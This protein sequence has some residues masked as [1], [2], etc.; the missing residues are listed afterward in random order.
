MGSTTKY[1]AAPSRARTMIPAMIM[2]CLDIGFF[3]PVS[4]G[5]S[6]TFSVLADSFTWAGA[7]AVFSSAFT[8][9]VP[10]F[11][12]GRYSFPWFLPVLPPS[13][14]LQRQALLPTGGVSGTPGGT[15]DGATCGTSGIAGSRT[16]RRTAGFTELYP[17]CKRCTAFRT[18]QAGPRSLRRRIHR[19]SFRA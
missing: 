3:G 10:V 9:Q 16:H 12:Q 5:T 18:G 19:I 2:V 11:L 15:S 1:T 14:G 4:F 13:R 7:G 8:G 6:L 17:R